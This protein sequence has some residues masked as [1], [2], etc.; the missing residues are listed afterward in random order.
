MAHKFHGDSWSLAPG[1]RNWTPPL[2]VEE[3]DPAVVHTT[4]KTIPLWADLA[5][6]DGHTATAKGFAQ[7]WTRE[8]VRIQWVEN[9]LPRYAWVAVGQVRRRTLSGR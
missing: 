5:Y 9:S 2:Q 8:V 3:P 6:P 1:T 7:A 4:D